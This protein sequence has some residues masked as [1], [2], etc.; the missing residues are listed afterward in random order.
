MIGLPGDTIA[1]RDDTVYV[2][3]AAA[4]ATT[5]A[6]ATSARARASDMT[7]ADLLT[8]ALPGRPHPVLERDDRPF[9]IQGEGEWTVPAGHYFVMGDNRDNSEDSRFWGLPAGSQPARQGVP[10]LDELGRQRRRGGFQPDRQQ[11]SVIDQADA[12]D[13]LHRHYRRNRNKGKGR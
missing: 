12:P 13:Q 10:D 2:N 3:G 6:A 9:F 5:R 11:D 8:E 1:Y 4:A 7:G